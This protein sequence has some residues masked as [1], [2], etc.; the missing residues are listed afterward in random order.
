MVQETLLQP[1]D[2]DDGSRGDLKGCSPP[3]C[4]QEVVLSFS[5]NAEE[6]KK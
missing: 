6:E 3:E 1:L 4:Q 5:W 2:E